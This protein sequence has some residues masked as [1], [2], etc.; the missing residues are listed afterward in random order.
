MLQSGRVLTHFYNKLPLIFACDAS[1][2]GLVVE[3]SHGMPN[4]EEKPIA[5]ASRTLT[6]AENYFHLDKEALGIIKVS[7]IFARLQV[8][9]QD[10]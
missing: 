3:L 7:S 1:P 10:R 5:F 2:Y 6:K 8:Q 4:G 9:D